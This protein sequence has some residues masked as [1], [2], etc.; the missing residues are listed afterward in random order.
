MRWQPLWVHSDMCQ[1]V[2]TVPLTTLASTQL[3]PSLWHV[4]DWACA[5]SASGSQFK[6]RISQ[7]F[8][9]KALL[10]TSNIS[11][12]NKSSTSNIRAVPNFLT[13]IV[14][15][16]HKAKKVNGSIARTWLSQQ[17]DGGKS[18]NY[19]YFSLKSIEIREK[20]QDHRLWQHQNHSFL[21][22]IF[23]SNLAYGIKSKIAL[24]FESIT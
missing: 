12:F 1:P 4:C 18:Q 2:N 10:C 3:H 21:Q 14:L 11:T 19:L 17:T 15:D 20:H 13:C 7:Y 6:I 24:T 16:F 5:H 22:R 8:K 23:S 9:W